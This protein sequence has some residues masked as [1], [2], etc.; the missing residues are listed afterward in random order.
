MASLGKVDFSAASTL[1]TGLDRPNLV[2]SQM[3]N[4]TALHQEG[5]VYPRDCQEALDFHSSF[6]VAGEGEDRAFLSQVWSI[7]NTVCTTFFGED[8]R[9][10]DG[11]DRLCDK[12][13]KT[14]APKKNMIKHILEAC[15]AVARRALFIEPDTPLG[16]KNM[17]E[18][19]LFQPQR[20]DRALARKIL[21]RRNPYRSPK[22]PRVTLLPGRLSLVGDHLFMKLKDGQYFRHTTEKG[23][24]RLYALH[25]KKFIQE[26]T[27][28][29]S[30][31][32]SLFLIVI[33]EQS[34]V[35]PNAHV[36]ALLNDRLIVVRFY[37]H[38]E[39]GGEIATISRMNE[40]LQGQQ[41]VTLSP[42]RRHR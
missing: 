18:V 27:S 28:I 32:T 29:E 40:K 10:E 11:K 3:G 41:P 30:R 1:P 20:M 35:Y 15:Q 9:S 16:I 2:L 24:I 21:S 23:K 14:E 26:G 33:G 39:D 36:E 13:F 42:Y 6:V 8:A 5:F 4:I 31:L 19:N 12:A 22:D 37:E 7:C 25:E 38:E 17:G 34:T